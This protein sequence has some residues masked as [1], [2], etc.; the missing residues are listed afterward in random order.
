MKT[1]RITTFMLCGSLVGALMLGAS[2]AAAGDAT[3]DAQAA[4]SE[5]TS[6]MAEQERMPAPENTMAT[7][8]SANETD[9]LDAGS[10]SGEPSRAETR[11]ESQAQ[12]DADNEAVEEHEIQQQV[13][14]AP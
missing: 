6:D 9:A 10:G 4:D 5:N 12:R 1:T 7:A 11:Q 2:P 8:P 14:S 3:L 13:W